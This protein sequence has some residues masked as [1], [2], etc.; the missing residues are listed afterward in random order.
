GCLS[1]PGDVLAEAKSLPP[2]APGDVVAFPSAGAYGLCASYWSFNGHP[3]PAEVVFD[4]TRIEVIR[5]RQSARAALD[6]QV[7]PKGFAPSPRVA[8][9]RGAGPEATTTPRTVPTPHPESGR[10][11]ESK[12][13]GFASAGAS[14]MTTT[15]RTVPAPHPGPPPQGGRGPET[16]LK[17]QPLFI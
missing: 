11:P 3:A 17:D 9:G 15:P 14:E 7:R 4:G 16:R 1:H 10:E 6:G 13:N 12:R 5:S 8:E 2:L